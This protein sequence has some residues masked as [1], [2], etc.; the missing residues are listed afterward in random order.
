ME[1]QSGLVF[2]IFYY[3]RCYLQEV[4]SVSPHSDV[5]DEKGMI[6]CASGS[7]DDTLVTSLYVSEPGLLTCGFKRSESSSKHL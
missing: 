5:T 7:L 6:I 2:V 1:S 3:W 4:L